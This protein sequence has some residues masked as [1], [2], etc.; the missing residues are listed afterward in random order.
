MVY[1]FINT[2]YNI[3][4]NLP[5]PTDTNQRALEWFIDFVFLTDIMVTFVT[6]NYSSEGI[7]VDNRYIAMRYLGGFFIP[8][9]LSC[10]PG[11]ISGERYNGDHWVYAFKLFRF[12][13]LGRTFE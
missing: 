6:D 8:D 13:Q 4:F 3:A 1:S 7:I 9:C 10:L 11:L 12:S 2:P 5:L